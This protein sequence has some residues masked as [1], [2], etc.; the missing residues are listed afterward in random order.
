MKLGKKNKPEENASVVSEK[1]KAK[2]AKKKDGKPS[3][4]K[5][6]TLTP[7][8][9]VALGCAALVIVLA[10]YL[11]QLLV[12]GSAEKAANQSMSIAAL[13]SAQ[14][15][16]DQRASFVQREL[17]SI[18]SLS[19]VST[20]LDDADKRKQME[21]NI[22]GYLPY[23]SKVHF[24][25]KGLASR[26]ADAENPLGF[27]SLDLVKKAEKGENPPPEAFLRDKEWLVQAAVP[28]KKGESNTISGVLLVV[29][30]KGLVLESLQLVSGVDGGRLSLVQVIGSSEQVIATK[31]EGSG[32][33]ISQATSI[34]HWQVRFKPAGSSTTLVDLGVYWV[35]IAVGALLVVLV[36]A[37]PLGSLF[38]SLRKESK[39]TFVCTT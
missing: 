21:S 36:V 15:Q 30:E 35:L 10:G 37:L 3:G 20:A 1:T 32:E 39:F 31:G 23:V 24:F 17:D 11:I 18:A 2:A 9:Y 34:P 22:E 28:V 14:L 6:K 29:F 19:A 12:I 4:A 7:P 5:F 26:N 27:S 33:E 25:K 8:L 13:S 38:K 16:I